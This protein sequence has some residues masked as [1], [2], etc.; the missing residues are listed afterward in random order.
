MHAVVVVVVD[1]NFL[2]FSMFKSHYCRR[3]WKR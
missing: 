3:S 1:D 2:I